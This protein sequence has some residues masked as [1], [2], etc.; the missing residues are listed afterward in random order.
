MKKDTYF[1]KIVRMKTKLTLSIEKT[2]L[3]KAKK[4]TRKGRRSLSKIFEDYLR[5]LTAAGKNKRSAPV[6]DSLSG[7]L[8]DHYAGKSYQKMKEEMYKDKYGL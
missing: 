7:I 1:I 6:T 4:L 2:V 5:E 8:S 3:E